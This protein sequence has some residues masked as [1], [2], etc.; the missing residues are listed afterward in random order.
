MNR[1]DVLMRYHGIRSALCISFTFTCVLVF[2]GIASATL[3]GDSIEYDG[4]VKKAGTTGV[5]QHY[6]APAFPPSTFGLA[7]T[8]GPLASPLSPARPLSGSE[9]E[10]SDTLNGQLGYKHVVI[11]IQATNGTLDTFANPLDPGIAPPIT[12]DGYFHA[13]SV[14][15]G[16]KVSIDH[17]G[18]EDLFNPPPAPY[19]SPDSATITGLGTVASPLH[20]VLGIA[21]NQ[22]ASANGAIKLNLYY[23]IVTN[24]VPEPASWAMLLTGMVGVVGVAARRRRG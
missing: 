16:Q 13:S 9:T 8:N 14:P 18:I 3:I 23:K 19:P 6:V 20:V 4:H 2:A 5:E 11:T 1:Y 12:F 21:A 10:F 15:V 24:P 22:V 17:V 7:V